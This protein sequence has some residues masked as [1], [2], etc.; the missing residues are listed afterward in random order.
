MPPKSR[1]TKSYTA[2]YKD[3]MIIGMGDELRIGEYSTEY[4]GWIWCTDK[5]GK[6]AWV[7]ESYLELEDD[8]TAISLFYYSSAELTVIEGE[9]VTILQ[10]ESGWLW[11]I[12]D[13]NLTGWIPKSC[14]HLNS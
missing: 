12:N 2:A 7:P 1:I 14:V 5:S 9:D 10:E 4:E 3:P 8:G 6:S 13:V 11:C